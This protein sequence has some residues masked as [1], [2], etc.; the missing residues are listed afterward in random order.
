MIIV[1]GT[2][3]FTTQQYFLNL[4]L[5]VSI[6]F[7]TLLLIIG[8]VEVVTLIVGS[9]FACSTCCRTPT[10]RSPVYYAGYMLLSLSPPSP[11]TTKLGYWNHLN[12]PIHTMSYLGNHSVNFFH[13]YQYS[14]GPG[15]DVHFFKMFKNLADFWVFL[16]LI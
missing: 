6:A 2:Y 13:I 8:L 9:C 12:L 16:S 5:D 1:K 10:V 14:P 3:N 15:N 11:W 7:N 4:Q